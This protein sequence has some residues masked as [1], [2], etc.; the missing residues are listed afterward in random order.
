MQAAD[1]VLMAVKLHSCPSWR[2][3]RLSLV[4]QF[5]ILD[6]GNDDIVAVEESHQ[7]SYFYTD[8]VSVPLHQSKTVNECW[9]GVRSR[10]NLD[11][12]GTLKQKS[13]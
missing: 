11:I 7:F 5:G 9:F 13:E 1:F 10:F 8:S 6:S 12:A 4:G 3:Q 2:L